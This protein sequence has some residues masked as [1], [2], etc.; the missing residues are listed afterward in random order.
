VREDWKFDRVSLDIPGRSLTDTHYASRITLGRW[1][2]LVQQGFWMP[3]KILNDAAM[4]ALGS[5][6]GGRML[7]WDLDGLDRR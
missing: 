4:Q 7:F 1:M 6:K 5:Y 3:V 2:R